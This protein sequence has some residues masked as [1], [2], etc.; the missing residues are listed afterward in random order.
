MGGAAALCLLAA[1]SGQS[2]G[3]TEG[4]SR[5]MVQYRPEELGKQGWQGHVPAGALH[6]A[7][8]FPFQKTMP[9]GSSKQRPAHPRRQAAPHHQAGPAAAPVLPVPQDQGQRWHQAPAL[10]APRPAQK[11]LQLRQQPPPPRMVEHPSRYLLLLFPLPLAPP[12]PPAATHRCELDRWVSSG[13]HCTGS[14]PRPTGQQQR[15]AGGTPAAAV[16]VLNLPLL[17]HRDGS[18]YST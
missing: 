4:S 18:G 8:P 16:Q 14:G 12:P 9:S 11:Q 2:V 1:A 6:G 13:V 17:Q 15:H 3:R 5:G 7:W 10:P